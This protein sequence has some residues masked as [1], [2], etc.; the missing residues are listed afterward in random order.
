L[1]LLNSGHLIQVS[2]TAT[3]QNSLLVTGFGYNHDAAWK[4]NMQLFQHFTDVS[5]GVR[6]LGAAAVDLCHVGLGSVDGYWEFNLSPWDCAAGVLMV[7]EAGGTVTTMDGR[8]FTVWEK[9]ILATN[10]ALHD[11]ML[12]AMKAPTEALALQPEGPC[13]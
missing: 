3:V 13:C 7:Q 2:D 6:R 5:R 8:P 10:G 12:A 1:L 11:E 9:S 4:Q